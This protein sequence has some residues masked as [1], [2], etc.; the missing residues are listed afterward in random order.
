MKNYDGAEESVKVALK[1][2]PK[3]GHFRGEFV[4][5]RILAAKGDVAGA[6]EHVSKYLALNPNPPDLDL[7]KGYLDVLGKP[8]AASVNPALEY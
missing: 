4:L 7:I 2:D 3:E 8:E 1:E 5:G 6:K